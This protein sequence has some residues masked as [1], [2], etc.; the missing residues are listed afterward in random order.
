MKIVARVFGRDNHRVGF[1]ERTQNMLIRLS[2]A[3]FK[4]LRK[5]LVGEVVESNN[6]ALVPD[7]RQIRL[8]SVENIELSGNV[9]K[10]GKSERVPVP[11][12]YRPG[13]MGNRQTNIWLNERS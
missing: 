5:F 11:A 3:L 8:G 13:N 9:F 12:F 1:V 7:R 6:R 2:Q 10:F 4:K